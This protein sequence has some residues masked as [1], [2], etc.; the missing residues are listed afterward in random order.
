M[1]SLSHTKGVLRTVL[2]GKKKTYF[3]LSLIIFIES[4]MSSISHRASQK[5]TLIGQ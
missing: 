3:I 5:I 4:H 2:G 1:T